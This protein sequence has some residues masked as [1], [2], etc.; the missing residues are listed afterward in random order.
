MIAMA[1][2]TWSRR[3]QARYRA[4]GRARRMIPTAAKPATVCQVGADDPPLA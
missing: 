2:D 3:F 4:G 1:I